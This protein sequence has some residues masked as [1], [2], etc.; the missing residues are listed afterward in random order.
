MNFHR[1]NGSS[2][3]IAISTEGFIAIYDVEELLEQLPKLKGK[4]MDLE[5][6]YDHIYRFDIDSRLIALGSRLNFLKKDSPKE[7]GKKAGVKESKKS[8]KKS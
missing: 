4:C 5:N 6:D 8:Q 3:L 2:I 7:D 1:S